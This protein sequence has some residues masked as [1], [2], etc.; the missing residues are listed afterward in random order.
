MYV[1]H[2]CE[3]SLIPRLHEKRKD[4]FS[5]LTW[6]GNRAGVEYN[7]AYVWWTGTVYW[8]GECGAIPKSSLSY[9]TRMLTK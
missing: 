8:Y 7:V 4:T 3:D 9:T 6:P 1:L 5:S 2:V